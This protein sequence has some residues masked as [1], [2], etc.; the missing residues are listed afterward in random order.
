[1]LDQDKVNQWRQVL[2]DR[3]TPEELIELLGVSVED[4]FERFLDECLE[5]DP[6]DIE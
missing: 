1:M 4:I 6:E 3:L 5:L 2:I